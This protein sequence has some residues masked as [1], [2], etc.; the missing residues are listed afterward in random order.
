MSRKIK[1]LAVVASGWHYPLSFYE[2]MLRQIRP[3]GWQ[4]DYFCISHRDPSYAIEEKKDHVFADDLRGKLDKKLY[5]GIATAKTIADLGWNYKEYPNTI[6]DWGNSNQWLEEHDYKKYDLLLFTHD[7]NLIIHDRVFADTIEDENFK[8]WDIL[9]NTIGMPPGSIR[10]SF[11]FFKPR[12]LKKLGGKFDLSET[13]LTRNGQFTTTGELHELFDWNTTVYPLQRFI[14]KNK[15]R[16]AYLSPAY[17]VSAYVIEGERGYISK[18]HGL[19]TA[20]EDAGLE[21]LHENKII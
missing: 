18:T 7:D 16:V 15:L 20:Y 21:Y 6:G 11:E 13:T 19:N 8:K 5:T 2:N 3:E 1:K 9:T 14:E 4:F 10:G 17:R 12:V